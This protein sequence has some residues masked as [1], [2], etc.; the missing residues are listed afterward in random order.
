VR[1]PR[2]KYIRNFFPFVSHMQP[3]QYKDGKEIVQTMRELHAAGKLT[4]LQDR[5]FAPTRPPEELYDLEADPGETRNLLAGNPDEQRATRDTANALRLRLYQWMADSADLGLIPE[6]VLEELGR[7]QGSKYGVLKP[8]DRIVW[9][10]LDTIE[11]GERKD[12]GALQASLKHTHPAV[13][14]WGATGLGNAG[15]ISTVDALRPLLADQ[16]GGVRVAAAQALAQLGDAKSSVPV[17]EREIDSENAIVGLYAI[18]GIELLE[19]VI[20][21]SKSAVER[22]RNSRYDETQRI[23]SRLSAK[24]QAAP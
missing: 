4:E 23:G 2:Y 19:E 18:R 14:W 1:T 5:I 6:P 13:R 3:N 10:I 24:L 8:K 11:A 12:F 9:T 16:Y 15:D 17:L 22:A 20:P 7:E 21:F